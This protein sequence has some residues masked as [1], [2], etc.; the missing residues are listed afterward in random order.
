[1]FH[2]EVAFP[3]SE[4][5]P[6]ICLLHSKYG[7]TLHRRFCWLSRNLDC[8]SFLP[9]ESFLKSNGIFKCLVRFFW[10]STELLLHF[11]LL[12][13][14]INMSNTRVV[15]ISPKSRIAVS[16][17]RAC[18]NWNKVSPGCVNL[19]KID[20]HQGFDFSFFENNHCKVLSTPAL[21][22]PIMQCADVYP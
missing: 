4:A 22:T 12:I 3:A 13:C 11:F 17:F 10:L 2:G 9:L 20:G 6:G 18:Q 16:P 21:S 15:V 14:S 8:V 19:E 5:F 7:F 1:M